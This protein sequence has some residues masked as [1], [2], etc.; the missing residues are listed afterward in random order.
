MLPIVIQ[1]FCG[2][3]G[4]H[5]N[6]CALFKV[7]RDVL[8]CFN[9]FIFRVSYMYQSLMLLRNDQ[10]CEQPGIPKI[11][12]WQF[13]IRTMRMC[14]RQLKIVGE[15]EIQQQKKGLGR[16]G[17][18]S[19]VQGTNML[20]SW[21]SKLF[22]SEIAFSSAHTKPASRA[23]STNINVHV[24]MYGRGG[25]AHH[26]PSSY[27]SRVMLYRRPMHCG[28]GGIIVVWYPVFKRCHQHQTIKKAMLLV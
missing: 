10:M 17:M 14:C 9:S 1:C 20:C 7:F 22:D 11:N 5:A 25:T 28:I 24:P 26:A 8:H 19:V 12:K 13:V 18:Q 3:G 27:S 15:A 2:S 23:V 21:A 16:E 6:I 4:V